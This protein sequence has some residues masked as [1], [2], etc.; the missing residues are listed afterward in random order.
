MSFYHFTCD[1]GHKWLGQCGLL[2]PWGQVVLP[3]EPK[4]IWFTD[5]PAPARYAMGLT[6][7]QLHCDR[8]RYRYRALAER[9]IVPWTEYAAQFPVK[10]RKELEV[11]RAPD[12]WFISE[13][14]VL[15]ILDEAVRR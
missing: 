2:R 5:Q 9:D 11:G 6:S 1:H 8:M 12:H 4:L 14:P 10:V 13:I 3:G 7:H 15:A